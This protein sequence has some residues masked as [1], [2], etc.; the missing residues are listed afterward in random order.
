MSANGYD[1]TGQGQGRIS[2]M[3]DVD[4]IDSKPIDS[5]PIDSRPIESRELP[6]YVIGGGSLAQQRGKTLQVEERV[7]QHGSF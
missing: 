3:L 7:S 6:G 1:N 5:K 2:S 4:P